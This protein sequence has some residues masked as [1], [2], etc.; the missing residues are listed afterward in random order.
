MSVPPEQFARIAGQINL[1]ELTARLVVVVGIGTVGSQ[2]AKE[3]ANSGV[4]RLCLIDG[5]QLQEANLARHALSRQ[6]VGMNKAEAL[7][8]YLAQEIPTLRVT[9]LDR[10]VGDTLT[11]DEL[12]KLLSGA[13]LIIAA[14]DDREAQRRVGRR[15][16]ALDI[17]AIFPGLYE[18]DGGEVFVQSSPHN[19]CFTCWD[20][21]RRDSAALRGVTALNADTQA[22]VQLAVELCLGVLDGNSVYA[23]RLAPDTGQSRLPQLFVLHFREEVQLDTPD[24]SWRP[25]CP[26]CAVGPSLLTSEHRRRH[27]TLTNQPVPRASNMPGVR[28]EPWSSQVE[29]RVRHR[30]HESRGLLVGLLHLAGMLGSIILFFP[31]IVVGLG[32]LVSGPDALHNDNG[33]V[34]AAALWVVSVVTWAYSAAAND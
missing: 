30:S 23:R 31:A 25:N 11:D 7:T 14:T 17:P 2:M 4:G 9:G 8:L 28:F 6:Y 16:L 26:G 32:V 5:K 19:P 33:T 22:L 27:N 12:D 1:S 18:N 34:S 10:H 13:D 21:F 29:A 3:L 15:A 24:V 20:A